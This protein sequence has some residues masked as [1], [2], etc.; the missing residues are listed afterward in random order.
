MLL[1][2]LGARH[3]RADLTRAGSA[4]KAALDRLLADP[5][6]RT[7]DLGGKLGC[8]AFGE[9]VGKVVAGGD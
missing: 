7:A 9:L 2:W 4:M 3:G 6:T 1:E 8:A 5:A